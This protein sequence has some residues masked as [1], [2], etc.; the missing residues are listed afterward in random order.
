MNL[1]INAFEIVNVLIVIL[2]LAILARKRDVTTLL[3]VLFVYGTLHFGF[4]AVALMSNESVRMLIALHNK[5]GGM[6]AKSATLSLLGVIF[7]L[8]GVQAYKAILL[9]QGSEKKIILHFLLVMGAILCG[10]A[11]NIR[12]GDWLQLK[13]VLSIEAMLAFLL[14]GYLGAIGAHTLNTAKIYSW[15]VAELLM[16]AAIDGLAVYEVFNHQSWA[17]TL[18]SSG[19]MVYRASSILFNPNLFAFWASLVYLGCAYGMYAYKEHRYVMVWGMV[20]ASIAIYMSGARSAGYL[21]LMVLFIPALFLTKRFNWLALLLLPI[22]ILSIYAV[23]AWLA[24]F[25]SFNSLGWQAI[26]LLGERFADAPIY[27]I[28]YVLMKSESMFQ[29]SASVPSGVPSE[30]SIAIEGRFAGEGRD[31]G[32]LVLYQ[33]TGWLGIAAM[34]WGSFMLLWWG[35]H[36]YWVER[37]VASVYALSILCCCLLTGLVMRFQIFPVWLFMSVFLIPCLYYWRQ[38][39]ASEPLQSNRDARPNS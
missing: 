39:A 35:V 11:L 7:A 38:S 3:L 20:L 15:G 32:W 13:N 33:D 8:L 4:A 14:I 9:S 17:G 37:S 16:F 18:E 27:L 1:N 10:Y 34:L 22:T 28:H 36:T 19:E 21:L 5:G 23:S 2:L 26:V 25:L 30:V 29:F 31:A 24:P 6:L 12:Q